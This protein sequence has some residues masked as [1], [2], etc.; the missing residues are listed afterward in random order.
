MC[1]CVC[2]N[3]FILF[4]YKSWDERLDDIDEWSGTNP[5]RWECDGDNDIDESRFALILDHRFFSQTK[6]NLKINMIDKF[7]KE[8][9]RSKRQFWMWN[10]RI[11]VATKDRR[12]VIVIVLIMATLNVM[13]IGY[14]IQK[15]N[16]AKKC[17]RWEMMRIDDDAG[18]FRMQP[19]E[20]VG[21]K[22]VGESFAGRLKWNGW[23]DF[24]H[25]HQQC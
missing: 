23:E 8:D 1:L 14:E 21:K 20:K 6:L 7:E 13:R 4:G 5:K 25:H 17:W 22:K 2:F 11:I 15:T 3:W 18:D 12:M 9:A 19:I 24:C 10:I 16:E